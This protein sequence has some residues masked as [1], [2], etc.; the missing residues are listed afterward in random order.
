MSSTADL[1]RYAVPHVAFGSPR[2]L[3]L[4][5]YIGSVGINAEVRSFFYARLKPAKRLQ[6]VLHG[7]VRAG[8]DTYPRFDRISS[9]RGDDDALVSFADPT[10]GAYPKVLLGWY[11]GGHGW[12]PLETMVEVVRSAAAAVG[13]EDVILIGGSGGG[14]AAMQLALKL[15]G[16]MAFVFNPQTAVMRYN[17]AVVLNYFTHAHPGYTAE[18]IVSARPERFDVG[19]AYAGAPVKPRIFYAQSIGDSIHV[20]Q[21]YIPF[22]RALNMRRVHGEADGVPVRFELYDGM[23]EG[24]GPPLV[25]EYAGLLRNALHWGRRDA[26]THPES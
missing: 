9:T 1:G 15:E 7:A 24:H 8:K 17:R 26:A 19:L 14:F 10:I 5:E 4:G 11:L 16:A 23:R 2:E 20:V 3:G 6:I 21:H 12:D 25:D 22:K 18:A 13:A